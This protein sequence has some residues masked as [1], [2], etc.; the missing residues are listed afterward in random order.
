VWER[1]GPTQP[2][3]VLQEGGGPG[4][5]LD[6]ASP[7]GK[8]LSEKPG[9]AAVRLIPVVITPNDLHRPDGSHVPIWQF[10]RAR[11]ATGEDAI[12]TANLPRGRWTLSM[13]YVSPVPLEVTVDGA[14]LHAVPSLEGPGEM[15]R[16]GT[17]TS[18]GGPQVVRIHAAAASP[19]ATF[20]IVLLGLLAFTPAYDHDTTVPLREACGRYV[21]WYQTA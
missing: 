9:T 6:C 5:V 12:A 10:H 7:D 11:I 4:A 17:F 13:Q 16:V 14:K 19:L 18:P 3:S 2:H 1:H 20:R 15:W 21:D 8:A